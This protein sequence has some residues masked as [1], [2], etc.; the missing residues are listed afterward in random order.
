MYVYITLYNQ[1]EV[2]SGCEHVAYRTPKLP[3]LCWDDDD[4]YYDKSVDL[5]APYFQTNS[6]RAWLQRACQTKN[7]WK[8]PLLVKLSSLNH[9]GF[10]VLKA[11][12]NLESSSS[13]LTHL[14]ANILSYIIHLPL[15]HAALF[16][17]FPFFSLAFWWGVKAISRQ[18][19]H[20]PDQSMGWPNGFRLSSF[21][22]WL[23]HVD[24]Q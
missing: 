20:L 12:S 15:R 2:I 11:V 22:S 13:L 1:L 14:S 6:A 5:G 3:F 7:W 21:Y 17:V 24:P 16:Y 9:P 10:L 19:I 23:I 4:Y 18:N 8:L